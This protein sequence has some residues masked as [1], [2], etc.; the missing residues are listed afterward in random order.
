MTDMTSAELP[1]AALASTLVRVCEVFRAIDHEMPVQTVKTFLLVAA[2]PGI[3]I[4]EIQRALGVASSTASR[5]VS[6]LGAFKSKGVPGH[7]LVRAEEH[8]MDRR[9]KRVVLTAKGTEL[10]AQIHATVGQPAEAA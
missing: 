3:L 8:P 10:I 1:H 9:F 2:S 7:G 6:A 5:N 4:N